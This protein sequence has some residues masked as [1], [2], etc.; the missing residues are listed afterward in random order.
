MKL[1]L[2]IFQEQEQI[3]AYLA[4]KGM[5]HDDIQLA[6]PFPTRL[7]AVQWMDFI[8]KRIG[9]GKIERH[10]IGLM[11]QKPWYGLS[12]VPKEVAARR[13]QRPSTMLA[14]MNVE[15]R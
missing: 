2:G 8:E 14:P 5:G 9:R 1:Q 11:N 4:A 7:Q 3:D 15:L 12:F 10:A 13:Q 6:G